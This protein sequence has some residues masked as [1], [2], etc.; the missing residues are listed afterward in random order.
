MP[1][2]PDTRAIYLLFVVAVGVQRLL[3]VR[4]SARH[5]RGLLERGGVEA[6]RAHLPWMIVFHAGFLVA[7]PLE[8]FLAHRPFA[9]LLATP[10]ILAFAAGQALRYWAIATLKERWSIRVIALPGTPPVVRGPYRLIRHPNYLGVILEVAALPLIHT[11]Y[12]TALAGSALNGA[13]LTLRVR[14]EERLLRDVSADPTAL[15]GKP[16]FAPH[17]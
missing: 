4:L 3:E 6:G 1:G 16:R 10:A 11:A 12:L 7:C 5:A 17:V 13:L 9:P 15:F 2:F 8:V 14:A